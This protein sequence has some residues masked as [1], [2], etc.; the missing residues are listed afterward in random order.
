M[1]SGFDKELPAPA[2]P[3]VALA[4]VRLAAEEKQPGKMRDEAVLLAD[5][6]VRWVL[7]DATAGDLV[8]RM[9]WLGWAEVQLA[10]LKGEK[11]AAAT[12]LREM[13]TLTWQHQVSATDPAAS[14]VQ[15]GGGGGPD[16]IGG[17]VFDAGAKGAT[18]LPTWQTA[19]PL[20]FI[21]A[22]LPD[23]RLT[24]DDERLPEIARLVGTMRFLRQLQMDDGTMWMCQNRRKSFGGI[25]GSLWDQRMPAD[26]SAMTLMAA[27]EVLRA[28]GTLAK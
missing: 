15:G 17:I 9:P 12:A 16:M 22:M 21:A 28:I 4:L 10:A 6:A 18:V 1:D 14:D 26:A 8:A 7:R 20:V 3:L 11:I 13:R 24:K 2:Q 19:R 25:R 5:S 23:T 27:C